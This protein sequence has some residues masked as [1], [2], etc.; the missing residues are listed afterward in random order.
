[1]EDK[2]AEKGAEAQKQFLRRRQ[3]LD[4]FQKNA[5]SLRRRNLLTGLG[6]GA[7]VVGIFGY[8]IMSVKQERIVEEMDEEAKIH[9]VRGPRT[10]AN[11]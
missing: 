9:I 4:Y 3:D 2:G 1:M 7:F 11:S 8:S 5:S 10:G 6:F